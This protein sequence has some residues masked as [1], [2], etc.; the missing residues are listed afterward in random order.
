[1]RPLFVGCQFR[2]VVEHFHKLFYT[3]RV[4]TFRIEPNCGVRQGT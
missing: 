2:I 1:M 3:L 4:A